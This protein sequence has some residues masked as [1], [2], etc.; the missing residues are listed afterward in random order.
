MN[1]HILKDHFFVFDVANLHCSTKQIFVAVTVGFHPVIFVKSRNIWNDK[2]S[3]GD[4]KESHYKCNK[5]N[6]KT[7]YAKQ[8]QDIWE[9]IFVNASG[10]I[11]LLSL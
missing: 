7:K 2:M 8:S 5:I 9:M 6:L 11:S 3:K 1:Q 4:K 10:V